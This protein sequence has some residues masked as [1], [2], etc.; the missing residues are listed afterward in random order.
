MRRKPPAGSAVPARSSPCVSSKTER[1]G[2]QVSTNFYIRTGNDDTSDQH[3][4][5]RS[6]GWVF[7]FNAQVNKSYDDWMKAL[8]NLGPDQIVM[9]EYNQTY[10]VEEFVDQ[11]QETRQP[12]G[13]NKIT[14]RSYDASVY[15]PETREKRWMDK[16]FMFASYEFC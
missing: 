6:A 4:G 3:I 15:H 10:T 11:V 7:T 9:D 2:K 12:W 8:L 5:K 16:G 13:P 14:S 1:K